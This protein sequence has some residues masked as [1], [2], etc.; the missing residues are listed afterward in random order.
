[1]PSYLS[2]V[3]SRPR[4]RRLV[5]STL[6]A[7]A[8]LLAAGCDR[9]IPA[10]PELKSTNAA[11]FTVGPSSLEFA[12]PPAATATLTASVQFTGLITARTSDANCATVSPLNVP[13]TKPQGS[14]LYI[15]TFTVR[16]V[17]VGSCTI[18]VTDKQ[19]R[20]VVVPVQVSTGLA[21]RIV[22]TGYQDDKDGEIYMVGTGSTPIRLTNSA[23]ADGQASVSPDR[24]KIAFTST[25]DQARGE[26]YVMDADGSDVVRLTDNAAQDLAPVFSPDGSTIAF[27]H[28]DISSG[29]NGVWIMNADGS[30][31]RQLTTTGIPSSFSPDGARLLY[32]GLDADDIF[33]YYALDAADGANQTMLGRGISPSFSPDGSHIVV[34]NGG[35]LHIAEADGSDPV[36][37]TD[38]FDL[39][40]VYSPSGNQIAFV[41]ASTGH[42]HL[43]KPDGTQLVELT[44]TASDNP[45]WK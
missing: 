19:G 26:I 14:P 5:G 27:S 43:V 39:D 34:Y 28:Q 40:P 35:G 12:I 45:D 20:R 33:T 9:E 15:A 22:Y 32:W 37:I 41:R 13:A 30:N 18:T 10:E 44:T 29:N 31:P 36:R 25:R 24:T 7:G 4:P 3:V 1:M 23:G 16:S 11:P 42:V 21:A 8:V 17:K 2:L 6:V 38:G